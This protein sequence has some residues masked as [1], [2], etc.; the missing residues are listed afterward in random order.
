[1]PPRRGQPVAAARERLQRANLLVETTERPSRDVTA[2]RVISSRPAAGTEV[3][4]QSTVTLLV[5]T[6]PNLVTLPDVLGDQQETA[7]AELERLGFIVNVDTR[8][9]TSPR[10]R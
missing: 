8:T 9:P 7:E 6:G 5:S 3:D 4:C 1:M 10:A 2:G